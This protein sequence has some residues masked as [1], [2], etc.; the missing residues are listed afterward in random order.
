MKPTITHI[1]F[2]TDLS[3]NSTYA[4]RHAASLAKTTGAR[5]HVLH[6]IEPLSDDARVTM[7]MFIQDKGAR[8]SA[9]AS[10]SS[11][12]KAILA[13]RQKNF[14]AAMPEEDRGI[15]DQIDTMEV[16]EGYPA[17]VILRRSKELECDLIVLGAHDHG[18]SHTFLGTVAKRVL[19][20]ATIPTLVVPYLPA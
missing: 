20:R 19:R 11:Y 12:V 17:E 7:Q 9:M 10:R 8:E 1:L 2:T 16:T 5:L 15:Q 4:L 13:E 18:F 3:E 6:V 14:W